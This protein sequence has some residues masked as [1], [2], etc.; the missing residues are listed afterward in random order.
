MNV[1]LPDKNWPFD[2]NIPML[3]SDEES[4]DWQDEQTNESLLTWEEAQELFKMNYYKQ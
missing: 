3:A 4:P 2:D 1:N